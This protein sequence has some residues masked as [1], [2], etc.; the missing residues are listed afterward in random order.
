[1]VE[2]RIPRAASR[3]T[4]IEWVNVHQVFSIHRD[5]VRPVKLPP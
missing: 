3:A 4:D 1:M 5:V 2:G